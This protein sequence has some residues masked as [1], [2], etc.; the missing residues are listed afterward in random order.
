MVELLAAQDFVQLTGTTFSVER[1]SAP[2]VNLELTRVDIRPS[3]PDQERFSLYFRG[4]LDTF[5]PQHLYRFSHAAT[6]AFDL[7]IV[8]IGKDQDAFTYEAVF[9][10]VRN[11]G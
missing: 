6:G 1:E 4:P 8:P 5:L 10:R 11:R 3:P 2:L 7:F 9:N